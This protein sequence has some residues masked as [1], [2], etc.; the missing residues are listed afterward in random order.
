MLKNGNFSREVVCA[1]VYLGIL[2]VPGTG[3]AANP[4]SDVPRQHWAY[5]AIEKLSETGIAKGYPDG[6]FQGNRILTRYEMAQIVARALARGD[7][8]SSDPLVSEFSDELDALGIRLAHL[9]KNADHV[10]ITGNAQL[11]YVNYQG[12]AFQHDASPNSIA[13]LRTRLFITGDVNEQWDY[14]VMLENNQYFRGTSETGDDVTDF[15]RLH[16]D[17]RAGAVKIT[18]GRYEEVIGRGNVYD[19]NVDGI[20]LL[21]E[22]LPITAIVQD[23]ML[24]RTK[25]FYVDFEEKACAA[26]RK[27]PNLY[28]YKEEYQYPIRQVLNHI[29]GNMRD[30]ADQQRK[31]GAFLGYINYIA[32]NN[33]FTLADLF[34]YND[35][36]NEENGEQSLDG[37]S[38]NFSNNYG[39]EGP[40]R[41][42]YIN[43]LRKLNW[44]N[45]VLMLMLA[46][47]VPLLWSGDEMGNSQNG[48]NNAYCQDNPTGWVN[49]KNEKSHRRQIE[50]LQQVIAFRKEHTV[51]SNPMPFQFSDYK[52][53][54]Y[55]D[56]S[57]HGTSAWMLEPTPDHLCLGML[58][59][60]AY[61]KNKK[62][63]VQKHRLG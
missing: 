17:G 3:I 11:S 48:N 21:G 2:G 15:Q 20:H 12:S 59:C 56:L 43:A 28:I 39:V 44:R 46:Q 62:E 36:H 41:K 29:N 26:S 45:A 54:G 18:A 33:G 42:R 22:H 23:G 37:S 63:P 40:T 31:Q 32:S 27:Y 7:I 49:W 58:Y 55:P 16:L 14:S 9:E 30:F 52:S 13:D 10:Q 50:F 35:K 25:I 57:Y 1:A 34:M 60:G 53:I 19:D 38:W 61:A 6:T 8:Q 24:S 4:F 5:K 47:G 51:L